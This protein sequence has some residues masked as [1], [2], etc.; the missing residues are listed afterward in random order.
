MLLF[1]VLSY[2][3]RVFK[4]V[5]TCIANK[6]GNPLTIDALKSGLAC[7]PFLRIKVD[8]DITKPLYER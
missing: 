7:G 2:W 4:V 3:V 1:N 5:G 6:I 8:I